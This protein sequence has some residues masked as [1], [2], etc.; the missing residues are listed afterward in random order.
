MHIEGAEM[1]RLPPPVPVL[2]VS[3]WAL[4]GMCTCS[5][6]HIAGAQLSHTFEKTKKSV[7]IKDRNV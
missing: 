4:E 3:M 6:V 1:K 5:R 2:F 7:K